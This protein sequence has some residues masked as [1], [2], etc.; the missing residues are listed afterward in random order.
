M[1]LDARI[2]EVLGAGCRHPPAAPRARV[3]RPRAPG[4]ARVIGRAGRISAA[5]GIALVIASC[6][7]APSTTSAIGDIPIALTVEESPTP[8]DRV[9]LGEVSAL[10]P[11]R[12]KPAAARRGGGVH[13]G[14]V[15]APEVGRWR[16]LT[17]RT[18]GIAAVWVDVADVGVASDLYYLAARPMVR[19]LTHAENCR[20]ASHRVLADHRP[21]AVSGDG[22]SPGDFVATGRG[23]CRGE[24]GKTRWAYFVAA[25]G[26]GPIRSLG[27]PTSGLYVVLAVVPDAPRAAQQ[28]D[29]LLR[30]ASFGGA[31]VTD[32]IEATRPR[33]V[34]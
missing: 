8:F 31:G 32:F 19:R 13:E 10:V 34:A 21:A 18:E 27:I 26:Y 15:A 28:L 11:D 29:R 14:I 2:V 17:G 5:V 16:A 33:T 30:G 25:P 23:T 7:G 9:T 24:A 6:Q 4:Y 3:A 20:T 22:A 1:Q 12:W